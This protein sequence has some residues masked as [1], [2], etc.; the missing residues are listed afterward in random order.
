MLLTSAQKKGLAQKVARFGSLGSIPMIQAPFNSACTA[1]HYE[2]GTLIFHR[3][4]SRVTQNQKLENFQ[5]NRMVFSISSQGFIEFIHERTA[6][7]KCSS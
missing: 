6:N 3:V 1:L 5:Y 4:I 7:S 2:N